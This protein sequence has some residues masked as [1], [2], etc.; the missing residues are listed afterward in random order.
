MLNR[1][2]RSI[3]LLAWSSIPLLSIPFD[4]EAPMTTCLNGDWKFQLV[5]RAD[6]ASW[7][8][9]NGTDYDDSS[10]ADIPV[11]ANWE[12]EGFEEPTY[13]RAIEDRYGLYRK[14]ILIPESMAGREIYLHFEAVAFGYT[15]WIN[16]QE[17]GNFR[18]AFL[19][20]QYQITKHVTPGETATIALKVTRDHFT[21]AFDSNDDWIL[22]GIYRDVY[23]FSPDNLHIEDYTILTHVQP[24]KGTA[25]VEIDFDFGYFL[26]RIELGHE[27]SV[28]AVLLDSSGNKVGE[29]LS[30]VAVNNIEFAPSLKMEFPIENAAY[31][32]AEEP[33]L[34][35]L[36]LTM[37]SDDGITSLSQNV[38]LREVSIEQGI[39]KINGQRIK[40]RGVCRH[41]IHPDVG[42]ALRDKH[43][44]EEIKLMKA[45][46]INSVRCAHYPHHPRFLELCDVYGLYVLD[47]VPFG[48]GDRWLP[49]P[50]ALPYLLE[51]ALLTVQRDKN[52]P[53]VI[54]WDIGNENPI[55]ANPRKAGEYVQLLDP[56]RPILFPGGNCWGEDA[57]GSEY[58]VSADIYSRHYPNLGM[59]HNHTVKPAYTKPVI[60]T[61]INHALGSAFGD[62]QSRW[63]LIE[64]NDKFAGAMIWLFADQ[65]LRRNINSQKAVDGIGDVTFLPDID[66]PAISTDK[67]VN[68]ET[69][70]DSH[71]V[72]GTDGIVDADRVPQTDY[73]E[74]KALYSP[75][76]ILS[77]TVTKSGKK[78][79]FTSVVE[80]QYDFIDLNSLEAIWEI[81]A[82]GKTVHSA[83]WNASIA[84]HQSGEIE[85]IIPEETLTGK[86]SAFLHLRMLHPQ[87]GQLFHRSF[88]IFQ[89]A[90]IESKSGKSW[91]RTKD[92]FTYNDKE[93]HLSFS[94]T[95]HGFILSDSRLSTRLKG[96]LLRT[97]RKRNMTEQRFVNDGKL[98]L[99]APGNLQPI[100]RV[101]LSIKKSGKGY[102]ISDVL[103]Y[104][105][106]EEESVEIETTN[107]YY[108]GTGGLLEISSSS[109]LEPMESVPLEY[110]L[111]LA[112]DSTDIQVSWA[113][114]GPY[115]SYPGKN[116]LSTPGSY[117]LKEDSKYFEGFRDQVD[118]MRLSSKNSAFHLQSLKQNFGWEKSGDELVVFTNAITQGFGTKFQ[119]PLELDRLESPR[120][121][122]LSITLVP[123]PE[124][125]WMS[126]L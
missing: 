57:P 76:K 58:P 29:S 34:Y 125:H 74:T 14:E 121:V 27:A 45:A 75:V 51:R 25:V 91:V 18:N 47:E 126:E 67:W 71:G 13:A 70:Y 79:V 21:K 16:G 85:L 102:I 80:N 114:S 33:N 106:G 96:P 122:N 72:Y 66:T 68:A 10:W 20:C 9:F 63:Q 44:I 42:R 48:Y 84:P 23:L 116:T 59:I 124:N 30:K 62:F 60:Y 61:E 32:N 46:N 92:S 36:V 83:K 49:K 52:F 50:E 77:P 100:E 81:E 31:W 55:S 99:W 37:E 104:V 35:K 98:I 118:R 108:L 120:E 111:A 5:D 43:W 112:F 94:L 73:Y 109:S 87:Y 38:G 119:L 4:H 65:G 69:V 26:N 103:R 1:I 88:R 105:V 95:S 3:V 97:G 22:S 110:G 113:G 12:M 82:D 2:V 90:S 41:D 7:A 86:E 53:S 24:D 11:P 15:L 40:L 28:N 78:L 89:T 8:G 39:L 107:T 54:I 19:P 117:S 123:E 6:E 93:T 64:D 101:D 17:V 115:P 56:S